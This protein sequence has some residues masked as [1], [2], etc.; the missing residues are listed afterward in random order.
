MLLISFF[1]MQAA[2]IYYSTTETEGFR[3]DPLGT[4]HGMTLKSVTEGTQP[5]KPFLPALPAINSISMV[6]RGSVLYYVY[7]NHIQG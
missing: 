4:Y 2:L 7:D 1:N 6:V 3:I 5:K